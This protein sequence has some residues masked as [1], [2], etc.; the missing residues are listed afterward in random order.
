MRTAWN[1]MIN[2][3][4][5]TSFALAL[6]CLLIARVSRVPPRLTC[7]WHRSEWALCPRPEMRWARIFGNCTRIKKEGGDCKGAVSR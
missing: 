6:P 7:W 4:S 2:C 1:G 5:R 3:A